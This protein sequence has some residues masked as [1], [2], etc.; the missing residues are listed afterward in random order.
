M[1]AMRYDTG[2]AD[3]AHGALTSSTALR[4]SRTRQFRGLNIFG[5][6][7]VPA[8]KAA[9]HAVLLRHANPPG[10]VSFVLRTGA[11][12]ETSRH[13][14]TPSFARQVYSTPSSENCKVT[15]Q[16][17]VPSRSPRR[18]D[19]G[20][21]LPLNSPDG[22]S[23]YDASSAAQGHGG[24]RAWL[25]ADARRG[26]EGDACGWWA[27]V[28]LPRLPPSREERQGRACRRDAL[29]VDWATGAD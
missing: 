24:S 5:G 3:S 9:D 29:M 19:R 16:A 25:L 26:F 21:L 14:P 11:A 12:I 15:K 28:S 22:T 17:P 4:R 8:A 2:A 7:F 18:T 6:E 23:T 1:S 27:R 10:L 13:C 20:P